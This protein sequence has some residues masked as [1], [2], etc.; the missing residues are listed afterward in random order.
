V[1]L[2]SVR[3]REGGQ[4][5]M[6]DGLEMNE[7]RS[8]SMAVLL[9]DE[10]EIACHRSD[11]QLDYEAL[12]IQRNGESHKLTRKEFDLLAILMQHA[13]VVMHREDLLM[14]VWGYS[15][16]IHTRTLDVHILR[17]RKHLNPIG[18]QCIETIVRVGYRYQTPVRP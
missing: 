2:F 7:L 3:N 13:G 17:V 5:L 16:T 9:M 4:P 8:I 14:L 11:L 1:P 18:L 10:N 6:D 12:T 15:S